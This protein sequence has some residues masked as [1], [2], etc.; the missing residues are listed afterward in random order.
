MENSALDD[1]LM[2]F[3]P[4][5]KNQ[6]SSTLFTGALHIIRNAII[7]H[8]E[9]SNQLSTK[10][11]K[12]LIYSN[13]V[14]EELTNEKCPITAQGPIRTDDFK[15][16]YRSQ[17]FSDLDPV[18]LQRKVW[19]EITL[20][21]NEHWKSLI[22]SMLSL[23]KDSFILCTDANG[24]H[25]YE[26]RPDASWNNGAR[27]G[28]VGHHQSRVKCPVHVLEFY[29][30]KLHPNCNAFFQKPNLSVKRHKFWY[31]P[32]PLCKFR[33]QNM[34][35]QI[36]IDAKLSR[37]YTNTAVKTTSALLLQNCFCSPTHNAPTKNTPT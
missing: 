12:E 8:L 14:F 36:S 23:K 4:D 27:E 19:F 11:C 31:S 1:I 7:K 33:L 13:A 22:D 30:S 29:L 35:S 10:N 6:E 5:I 24:K 9:S 32:N 18:S 15:K 25:Y 20:Y 3:Y 37:I 28:K 34:M 2:E 17:V 16:L 26:I 21:L